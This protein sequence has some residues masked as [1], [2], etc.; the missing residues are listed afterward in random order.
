MMKIFLI[1]FAGLILGQLSPG[2]S[3]LAVTSVAL[4]QDQRIAAYVSAGI[5]SATLALSLVLTLAFSIFSQVIPPAL[6]FA[7]II[8]G[9][10]LL[11][12]SLRSL[13]SAFSTSR[14]ITEI[15]TIQL[16]PKSAWTYGFIINISNP[17]AALV[18]S[19]IISFL[20]ASGFTKFEIATFSLLGAASSAIV[21]G[22][23]A[24]LFSRPFIKQSYN[25][26]H[27]IFELLFGIVFFYI[28]EQ[29]IVDV[30]SKLLD[31]NAR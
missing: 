11:S 19:G 9:S 21:F 25:K 27:Q 3:F 10:Y 29:L 24:L 13:R 14:A 26:Y 12:L 20:F 22:S 7:E 15:C 6:L 1:S 31:P 17:K 18:W 30:L 8:G 16:T 4:R 23:F 5:A 28:A 2:P